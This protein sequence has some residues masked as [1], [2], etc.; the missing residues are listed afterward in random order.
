M[1]LESLTETNFV[2]IE[3]ENVAIDPSGGQ[4][5]TWT[6]LFDSVPVN[7]QPGS[8]RERFLFA[9]RQ[10]AYNNL[11]YCAR[12]YGVQKGDRLT[13]VVN[14]IKYVV[15]GYANVAGQSRLFLI[16]ARNID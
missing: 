12:D 10:I 5:V 14:K 6:T 3:R 7:I 1:S 9:Q 13:D 8:A 15:T 16:E 4:L 2:L 11:I